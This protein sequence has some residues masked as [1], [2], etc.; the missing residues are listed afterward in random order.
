MAATGFTDQTGLTDDPTSSFI[1]PQEITVPQTR[2]LVGDDG[3]ETVWE[4]DDEEQDAFA[5]LLNCGKRA[6]TISIMGHSVGIESLNVDDDLRVG[7]FTKDYLGTEAYARAVQLATCAAGIKTIDGQPIYAPWSSDE[8]PESVF[9]A[10]L[11]V[12][13]KAHASV[14]MEAYPHIL[15][16]D[17]EFAE[18][19]MKLGKL[20]G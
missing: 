11:N 7:V 2:R 8:S 9:E 20:T 18:L 10:K 6:K 1:P 12:L 16:L 14:I 3:T 4:P 17:K 13:R 15:N 5:T 19:A